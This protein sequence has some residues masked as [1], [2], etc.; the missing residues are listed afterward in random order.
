MEQPMSDS[1]DQP[2]R[3]SKAQQVFAANVVD[4][5]MPPMA[6][7]PDDF[8]QGRTPWNEFI[9]TLFFRGS[10]RAFEDWELTINP[11]VDGQ[12]AFT[13]ISTILRSFEPKH[14]H[15]EAAAAWLASRW[16]ATVTRKAGK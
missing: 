16:F 6:E 15:K 5:L 7:I 14:E 12:L 8:Q 1:F 13:H 11:D 3:I 9:S 4:T 10:A 2:N